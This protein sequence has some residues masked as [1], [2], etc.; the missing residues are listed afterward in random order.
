MLNA[1]K[2]TKFKNWKF[3]DLNGS[4]VYADLA[5]VDMLTMANIM[6]TQTTN[7]LIAESKLIKK[8]ETLSVE[9]LKIF[10]ARKEFES[11]IGA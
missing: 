10:D 11:I 7:V 9:E 3:K 2:Q 1:M 6:Q 4:D 8:L 5:I